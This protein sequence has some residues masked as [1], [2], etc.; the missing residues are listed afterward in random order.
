MAIVV[1]L[2]VNAARAQQ[3]VITTVAGGGPTDLPA[4]NANLNGPYFEAIDRAGNL[5]LAGY[6][7]NQIFKV[8]PT[9]LLTLIAGNGIAEYS[10]DGGL[11]TLASLNGPTG[12]AVDEAT[13]ANVYIADSNNCIVRKVSGSSGIITTVAG[14]VRN[15][16][17]TTCGYSGNGGAA[18]KAELNDPYAV[19]ID[20]V[21]NDLYVV[22]R[23]N[24][25]IRKVAGGSATGIIS[26]IAG[27]GTNCTGARP[28]GDGGLATS[29]HLCFPNGVALDT[30]ARPVNV[31]ISDGGNQAYCTMRDVVGSTGKI[32]AVAGSYMCGFVDN[33]AATQAALSG[34]NQAFIATTNGKTTISFADYYNGRIRQFPVTYSSSV[35]LAGEIVTIAGSGSTSYC[36]DGGSAL[37]ACM[38]PFGVVFDSLGDFYITDNGNNRI[39]KVA[40][41]DNRISTIAGWGNIHYSDPVTLGSV[42]ATGLSL[43]LPTAVYSDPSSDFIYA[44]GGGAETVYAFESTTGIAKTLAGNGVAGYA[45][46]GTAANS[47]ATELN[48]PHGLAKDTEGN[49]YIGDFANCAVRKV[50]ASTG[51]IT[52]IAG[53]TLGHLNGC[54]YGGD[55]GAAT[56][57]KLDGPVSLITDKSNNLYIAEYNNCVVR[58]ITLGTGIISTVAGNHSCGFSGDGG[59]ATA[60]S[61]NLPQSVAVDGAGNLLIADG[62]NNRIRGVD[63]LGVITTIAGDGSAGFS[64]DGIAVEQ[65]INEPTGVATDPNG[66]I[67]FSDQ[68]NQL[69]RWIDPAGYLLSIAG[70]AL[71]AGFRGDGERATLAEHVNELE[72]RETKYLT[73][74]G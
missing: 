12:I 32:Y 50:V 52:T 5:Y 22:D 54:G 41:N 71:T 35:P 3:D 74:R 57:A 36:G 6:G 67:F 66:N 72:T 29:A 43:Y 63:A 11:A 65:S 42:P 33:V 56:A 7:Q 1:A 62:K 70:T 10:G 68:N 69:V 45:G 61:L 59:R 30:T 38:F 9:G 2:S 51:D 8:S 13:P 25:A 20:P 19:G 48:T 18:D 73:D 26:T 60:A 23:K 44:G 16:T 58:R 21:T 37:K 15:S 28:Y 17:T 64:G 47:S 27:T 31:F 14:A 49:V 55:G 24:G 46:D 4:V 53:G 39:R 34:V 40:K